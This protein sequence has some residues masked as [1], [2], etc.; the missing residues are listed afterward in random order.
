MRSSTGCA[1]DDSPEWS[2][3][4]MTGGRDAACFDTL[5]KRCGHGGLAKGGQVPELSSSTAEVCAL[6]GDPDGLVALPR[7]K[8]ETG[9]RYHEAKAWR[10]PR[11]RRL[12]TRRTPRRRGLGP[13]PT[14]ASS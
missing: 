7:G 12:T 3:P 13:A 11:K 1:R 5:R 8:T 10:P 6:L 14:P 9:R 4:A 2:K